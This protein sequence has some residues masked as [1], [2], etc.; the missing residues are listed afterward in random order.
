MHFA[1][2]EKPHDSPAISKEEGETRR[3]RKIR[4]SIKGGGGARTGEPKLGQVFP[5]EMLWEGAG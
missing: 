1:L 3:D 5:K 4:K 2:G